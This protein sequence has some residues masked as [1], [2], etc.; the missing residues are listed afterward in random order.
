M[1]TPEI[2]T[3]AS[4]ERS[5]RW[6]RVLL[7]LLF[8]GSLIG[9]AVASFMMSQHESARL[10]LTPMHGTLPAPA[11][12]APIRQSRIVR[13]RVSTGGELLLDRD[14]RRCV[15]RY[16]VPSQNGPDQLPDRE[17]KLT[18]AAGFDG[19]RYWAASYRT[20]EFGDLPTYADRITIYPDA[21]A[22][23]KRDGVGR[24]WSGRPT[25][26]NW[27]PLHALAAT[28]GI[29]RFEREEFIHGLRTSQRSTPAGLDAFSVNVGLNGT[30][31]V[32]LD[33]SALGIRRIEVNLGAWNGHYPLPMPSRYSMECENAEDMT[34]DRLDV[35]T[36]PETYADDSTETFE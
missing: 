10:E 31:L 25:W 17:A 33:T 21:E 2:H 23:R 7:P 8:A 13:F 5:R 3:A 18:G 20:N 15:Y 11:V 34:P 12:A 9:V 32:S 29:Q 35:I 26:Y 28:I 6:L 24:G 36:D 4:V 14:T 30:F 1:V 19:T 16:D 22:L 27:A